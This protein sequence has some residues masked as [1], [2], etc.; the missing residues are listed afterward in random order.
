MS[1]DQYSVICIAWVIR[2]S[3]V[4]RVRD[5]IYRKLDDEEENS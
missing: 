5:H 4:A 2:K 3:E 1:R